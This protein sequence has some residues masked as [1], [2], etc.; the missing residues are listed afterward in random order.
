M[1]KRKGVLCLRSP[2]VKKQKQ[3]APVRKSLTHL[4]I[5]PIAR[6]TGDSEVLEEVN[7]VILVLPIHSPFKKSLPMIVIPAEG[8]RERGLE[9]LI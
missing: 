7:A 1:H 5:I 9:N 6:V 8:S 3:L 2:K 4:L